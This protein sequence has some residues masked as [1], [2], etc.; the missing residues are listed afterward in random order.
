MNPPDAAANGGDQGIAEA[1]E[2]LWERHRPEEFARLEV[3]E[4]AAAALAAGEL[5]PELREAA[6]GAAHKLRGSAGTFGRHRATEIAGELEDLLAGEVPLRQTSSPAIASLVLSLRA[7]L[8]AEPQPRRAGTGAEGGEPLALV[9]SDSE[10]LRARL[11]PAAPGRGV[12]VAFCGAAE[13]GARLREGA[14]DVILLDLAAKAGAK[15]GTGLLGELAGSGSPPVVVLAGS[16]A[17]ADRVQAA[18]HGAAGFVDR[19]LDPDAL[20]DVVERFVAGLRVERT[21]VLAVDDDEA[22]LSALRALLEPRGFTVATAESATRFWEQLDDV[23]P[24]IAIV[25]LDMPVVNGIDLCRAI[26]TDPRWAGLPLLILTAYQDPELVRQAFAAGVDDY[27]TKPILEKELLSRVRNRLERIRAYREA[28]ERDELTGVAS[29]PTAAAAIDRQIGI[30]ARAGEP[31]AVALLDVDGLA[32]LNERQGTAAGDAVLR[33]A[34]EALRDEFRGE[35]VG[36]WD[37]DEFVIGMSGLSAKAAASLVDGFLER[38]NADGAGVVTF[39]AGVASGPAAD[40]GADAL[41]ADAA[42]ALADAKRAGGARLAVAGEGGERV[43]VAV[44]EDDD[45]VA[46][47][48]RVALETLGLSHRRF[49]DGADAVAHLSGDA[50]ELRARLVLLDW[51]L[52][53]LDGLTVLRRLRDDGVLADTRVIM[54]TARAGETET[55]KALE[56]GAV[57]HVSKPFSV[58]VL[59]ERLRRTLGD[60]GVAPG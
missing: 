26:R 15:R 16:H 37:G 60:T 48:L 44:V 7:E 19:D 38:L 46:D 50:P 11:E 4:D 1:L 9:I 58:P 20:L 28:V 52:P 17:L 53:A 59:V 45:S 47:V 14:A 49:S 40:G 6:R 57:D 8:E 5:D 51:D 24:D 23:V 36:R 54:L 42:A 29:R 35:T 43:D 10:E 3:L 2:E 12:R 21:T 32:A 56:L 55:V 33:R 34:G 31:M 41:L 27:V 13:A 18:H 30:A 25:D 39:S 22:V